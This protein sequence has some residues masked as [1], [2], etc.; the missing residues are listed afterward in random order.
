MGEKNL[1]T[2]YLN[3]FLTLENQ[4]GKGLIKYTALGDSLS[5]GVGSTDIK[6]TFVYQYALKLSKQYKTVG[7]LNLSEPGAVADDVINDQISLTI[8]EQPDVVT[9]LIGT[10]DIHNK[11][12]VYSFQTNYQTILTKIINNTNAKIDV[13]NIPYLGSDKIIYP[14]Y[15][16]LLDMKIKQFNK[17]ILDLVTA[18]NTNSRIKYIDLYSAT[19]NISKNN[20]NYYS[21]DLFHPSGE[22]YLLWGQTINAN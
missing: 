7:V 12:T 8:K 21:S 11:V 14:P 22:G 19:Y 9:L 5:A 18:L 15:N 13:I 20:P 10:N 6:Q 2:P 1:K 4:Q 16:L 17:V 3:D